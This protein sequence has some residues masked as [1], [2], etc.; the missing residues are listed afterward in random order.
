MNSP[1]PSV[2]VTALEAAVRAP[3]PFNTQPWLFEV[4]DDRITLLL[5][6]SRVLTVADPDAREAR[7]SCGA[8]LA[9]LRIALRAHDRVALVELMPE[10]GNPDLL[11]TVRVRGRRA[12]IS[13][14]RK[15]AE[16]IPKRHTNR[17]PFL[18]RPV[19]L[20]A[21][22]EL[23]AAADVEGARLVFIDAS[24][25]YDR[26]VRLIREAERYQDS[27]GEY[28]HEM[29]RWL[30]GPVDRRDGVPID[31][32]GP[33]PVG[34]RLLALR[35]FYRP[36]PLPPRLFEQQ[37]LLIAVVTAT[38]GNRYDLIAGAGMQR[39]LLTA[40]TLGLSASFLSQPFEVP[41]TRA[42]LSASF[43]GDGEVHALLRVGYGYPVG[44]TPRRAVGD[45]T[46]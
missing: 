24:A 46:R 19:P 43:R 40:C 25:R 33:P 13:T 9:N 26:L 15:L 37:P 35:S 3:S 23:A 28:Q 2:I 36:S 44:V 29:K 32:V 14:E 34:N 12:S 16:A 6:R 8:A 17:H 11:A 27:H 7:L 30:G 45:V 1:T 10:P 41:S 20:Q 5:D 4:D 42:D 21:R 31:A 22:S 18:E 38:K 39:A